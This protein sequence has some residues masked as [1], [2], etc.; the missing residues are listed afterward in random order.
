MQ[1]RGI[2]KKS[3]FIQGSL[4]LFGT[5]GIIVPLAIVLL[6]STGKFS[7]APSLIP[8][9][10]QG[11][12]QRPPKGQL[13]FYVRG[14]NELPQTGKGA[15]NPYQMSRL[16]FLI[17]PWLQRVTMTDYEAKRLHQKLAAILTREQRI[18]MREW[19]MSLGSYSPTPLPNDWQGR[20]IQEFRDTYNPFYTPAKQRLFSVLPPEM[21]ERYQMRYDERM[22][23]LK[24]WRNRAKG[25]EATP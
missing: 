18:Q 3:Q 5:F 16:N 8:D 2:T 1:S 20:A 17:T 11:T 12:V 21:R 19:Q 15:L 10:R 14:L 24:Q 23:L 13:S 22:A 25:Q 6:P 4:V 9:Y 7:A